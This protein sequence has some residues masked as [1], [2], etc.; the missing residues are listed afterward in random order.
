MGILRF[1]SYVSLFG[2]GYCMGKGIDI[3]MVIR[4]ISDFVMAL[5]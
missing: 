2:L 5:I 3:V 1:I 4:D